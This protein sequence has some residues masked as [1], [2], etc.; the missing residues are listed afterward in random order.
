MTEIMKSE[1]FFFIASIGFTIVAIAI[2]ILIIYLIKAV[3]S[4]NAL[5]DRMEN[6]IDNLG[7]T[8]IDLV[9]DIRSSF[10]YK[11]IFNPKKKRVLSAKIKNN[12]K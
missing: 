2:I 7:D 4:F 11:M 9:D 12:D 10:I 5:V 6:E 1:I 8:A 3:R